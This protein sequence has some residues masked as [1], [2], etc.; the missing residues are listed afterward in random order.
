VLECSPRRLDPIRVDFRVRY[1]EFQIVIDFQV[2]ETFVLKT[3]VCLPTIGDD[4]S[5]GQ[6]EMPDDRD[7][8][9]GVSTLHRYGKTSTTAAFVTTENPTT[10]H[11][12][13]F[14]VLPF[15]E[16]RLVDFDLNHHHHH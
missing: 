14:V 4:R 9:G 7:Q 16:L 11:P 3:V 12:M 1:N 6:D 13:P 10:V 5:A 2:N 8:V 15:P